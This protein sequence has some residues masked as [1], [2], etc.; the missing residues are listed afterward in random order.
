M[1][2]TTETETKSEIILCYYGDA[3]RNTLFFINN[4]FR[5]N[6][7]GKKSSKS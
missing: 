7:V 3:S 1:V 6:E 5:S 4:T 2:R